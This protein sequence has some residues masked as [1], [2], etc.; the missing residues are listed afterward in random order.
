MKGA[1]V[2]LLIIHIMPLI[3]YYQ[4]ALTGN[5][6]DLTYVTENKVHVSV[7]APILNEPIFSN[8]D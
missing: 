6:L 7:R 2:W 4:S 1:S 8:P 3:A 5:S